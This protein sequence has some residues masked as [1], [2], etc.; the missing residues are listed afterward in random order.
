M[1][2]VGKALHL[3]GRRV[4]QRHRGKELKYELLFSRTRQ[5]IQGIDMDIREAFNRSSSVITELTLKRKN[6]FTDGLDFDLDLVYNSGWY[7]LKDTAKQRYDWDG[8]HY[9]AV[10]TYG[11]EQGN[12]PSDGQNRSHEA[13]GK[14]NL[15]YTLNLLHQTEEPH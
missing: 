10:S 1:V 13:Y 11:G 4:H 6:F 14:L 15:C 7:G 5:Q 3:I 2:L 12:F 9:P 8:R